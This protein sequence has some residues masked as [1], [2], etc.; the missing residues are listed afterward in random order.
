MTK[1]IYMYVCMYVKI[2]YWIIALMV[3]ENKNA[4]NSKIKIYD[5][6]L[7]RGKNIYIGKKEKGT[8][9]T[10]IQKNQEIRYRLVKRK[11]Q[12]KL[13]LSYKY[14]KC[15]ILSRAK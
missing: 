7:S 9:V 1:N 10:P 2:T 3:R 12:R 11:K 5:E 14:K 4:S 13:L 8:F 6:S 15:S